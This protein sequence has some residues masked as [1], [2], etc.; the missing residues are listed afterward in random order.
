MAESDL[1]K[2]INKLNKHIHAQHK[3]KTNINMCSGTKNNPFKSIKSIHTAIQDAHNQPKA[4]I[5]L[6]CFYNSKPGLFL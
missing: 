2:Y 6:M 4:K 1:N 3:H 5:N